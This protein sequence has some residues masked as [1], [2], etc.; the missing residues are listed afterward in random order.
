MKLKD[1]VVIVTGGAKGIGLGCA[2]VFSRH[3]AT[4]VI[5]DKDE[6]G[7]KD[8]ASQIDNA[9]GRKCD[10]TDEAE[11]KSVID[12]VAAEFGHLD[13]IVNN[14]GWHPPSLSIDE[15]STELFEA[16]LRLNLTGTFFG[17]KFAAP[18]LRKS[19][20]NI[21]I[22]ASEVAVIGQADACAY[23]ASKCGQLGLMR[24]LAIDL[25]PQ[26]V[27]VNAIC[28]SNVDTP[29]MREWA[30]TLPDPEMGVDIACSTQPAGRLASIEEIGEVAAF[31]ASDEA[32]FINGNTMIADH[33]AMLGYGVK[34]ATND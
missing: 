32:S 30:A 13:C 14:A 6:A 3:G 29:L 7:A 18:H 23:A 27:R 4:V 19:G 10:V 24:A 22:I 16:Q 1:K 28:P 26:G 20:G 11:M 34:R 2:K 8:A 17:C 5:A 33:G 25:V 15:T 21:V 31:L 9:H 12:G